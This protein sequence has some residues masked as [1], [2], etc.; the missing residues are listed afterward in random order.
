[1]FPTNLIWH[2]DDAGI[3]TTQEVE[4]PAQQEESPHLLTM[5]A[6]GAGPAGAMSSLAIEPPPGRELFRGQLSP[7]C[8]YVFQVHGALTKDLRDVLVAEL[9]AAAQHLKTVD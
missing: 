4:P 5:S 8:S 3:P 6:P 1:M 2:T 9:N 7:K